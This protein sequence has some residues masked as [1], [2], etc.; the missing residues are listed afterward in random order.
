MSTAI[1]YNTGTQINM[2][3]NTM[4]EEILFRSFKNNQK[5]AHENDKSE[6]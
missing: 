3:H 6:C 1:Q 4:D 5:R 2:V